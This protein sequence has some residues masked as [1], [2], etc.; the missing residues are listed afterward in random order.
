MNEA[1][2]QCQKC[3]LIYTGLEHVMIRHPNAFVNPREFKPV[4]E[5]NSVNPPCFKCNSPLNP[6]LVIL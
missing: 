2:Y 5:T 6:L 1:H 3:K 4:D